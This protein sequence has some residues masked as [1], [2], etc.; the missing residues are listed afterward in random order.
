MTVG[1]GFFEMTRGAGFFEVTRL[2][3]VALR[4]F[5]FDSTRALF[6]VFAGRMSAALSPMPRIT[7]LVL[8]D[9]GPFQL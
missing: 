8:L 2:R 3:D 4:A 6:F 5:P 1:A 7:R 9:H